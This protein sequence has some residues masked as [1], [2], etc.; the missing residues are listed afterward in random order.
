MW[1]KGILRKDQKAD[2]LKHLPKLVHAYNYMRLAITIYRPHYLMFGHWLHLPINYYFPTIRAWKNTGM[3]I[4]ILPSYVNDYGKPLKR[5]KCSPY[6]RQR[7]RSGTTMGKLMPFHW[8]QVT[9]SWLKPMPM[10]EEESEGQVGEGTVQSGAPSHGNH[11]FY[12][13]KTSGQDAHESFTKINFF[14]SLWQRGLIS[15]WLCRLSG[16]GAPTP[17]YRNKLQREVRLRKCH[18]VWTVHLWPSIRQVR[19]LWDG[20][21]GNSMH[22]CRHFPELPG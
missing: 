11:P 7:D 6:Q 10:G 19:L 3:L 16:P 9:L 4:T 22:S 5:L 13:V 14:S 12:L 21:T 20:W 17:P 8:N 2:W 1:M 15:V 18:K